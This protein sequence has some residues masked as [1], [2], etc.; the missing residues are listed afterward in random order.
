MVDE[1][2]NQKQYIHKNHDWK[3][4]RIKYSVGIGIIFIKLESSQH[5]ATPLVEATDTQQQQ[6]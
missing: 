6:Y 3:E 1:R 4:I 2:D 5:L